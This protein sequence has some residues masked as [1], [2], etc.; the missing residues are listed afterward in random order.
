MD[1]VE[2]WAEAQAAL[3]P[4]AIEL[5]RL[6]QKGVELAWD[7]HETAGASRLSPYMV[8]MNVRHT[9]LA[10]LEHSGPA[11]GAEV[12]EQPNCG[13]EV[14]YDHF[15]LKLRKAD[16]GALP[17]PGESS[18]QAAFYQQS[19][20]DST[21][22]GPG[23]RLVALLVT[24]DVR[25]NGVLLGPWLVKPDGE[26]IAWQTHLVSDVAI[27]SGQ[28]LEPPDGADHY[29][30]LDIRREAD[31]DADIHDDAEDEGLA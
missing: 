31:V 2:P 1:V 11:L 3:R 4:L 13:V 29:D 6:I 10:G 22:D 20:F 26:Y 24:W 23:G 16:E 15:V 9:V 19:L 12:V 7:L 25:S 5:R 27:D 14:R 30:G 17:P 8:S 28:E 21:D 18:A